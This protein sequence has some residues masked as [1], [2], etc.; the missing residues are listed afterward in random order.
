M[1]EIHTPPAY[2]TSGLAFAVV[3][4]VVL[5]VELLAFVKKKNRD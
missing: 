4:A 2:I 3:L 5:V 1:T